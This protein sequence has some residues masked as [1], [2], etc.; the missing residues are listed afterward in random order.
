MCNL[1]YIFEEEI[2]FDLD[3]LEIGDAIHISSTK[4]PEGTVP[5]ITDR[6]FTIGTVA[7]PTVVKEPETEAPAEDEAAEGDAAESAESKDEESSEE[8]KD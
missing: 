1:N 8:K 4:L 5:T 7:A 3:G 6:D 2:V